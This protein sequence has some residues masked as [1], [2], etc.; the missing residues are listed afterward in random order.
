MIE[1]TI[2]ILVKNRI[3][4]AST[5]EQMFIELVMPLFVGA[6]EKRYELFR[7]GKN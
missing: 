2:L 7:P 3:I 6:Q 1:T 5:T 4:G